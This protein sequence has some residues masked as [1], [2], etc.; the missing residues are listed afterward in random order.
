MIGEPLA[1]R[2]GESNWSGENSCDER[3]GSVG[4]GSP[5]FRSGRPQ[6]A[7]NLR[8]LVIQHSGESS[9]LVKISKDWFKT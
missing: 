4:N 5:S 9:M 2:I 7:G 8:K 1:C 3:S 6:K